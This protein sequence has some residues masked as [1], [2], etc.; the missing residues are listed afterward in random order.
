MLETQSESLAA[1]GAHDAPDAIIV[2][3]GPNGLSAA[4]ALAEAGADVLVLE[5][6]SSIGG[7]T[8]TDTLTLP[9]FHHDVC[10]AAHPMGILSPYW[11]TLPLEDHGLEWVLPDASVAHPLDDEPAVML[12]RDIARTADNLGADAARWRRM[13]APLVERHEDLLG[14]ALG[15]LGIPSHPI[16]LMRFGLKAL[17]PATWLAKWRFREDRARALFAGCAAHSILPLNAWFTSALGVIFAVT[18]HAVEWPVAKGGSHAITYALASYLESQGGRILTDHPVR[19][20][21]DLP[22]ARVVLFDTDPVQMAE[23]VGDAL[24][25]G[26]RSRLRTY[27]FGP[28]AFKVDWA[29]DEPIPWRDP[30]CNKASTVHVGGT[31]DEVAAAE[32]AIW[33]GKHPDE[34]FVLVVQQ[35]EFDATRAPGGKH[36]GYAYCHVPHG[37]SKDMTAAIE[38]QIERFAPGFKDTILARHT[39]SVADFEAYNPNYV[40]GAITGGAA[41]WRQLFTRPVARI[42]PYTT[43]NPRVLICSASTPPGGGVHGMCGYH[44]AQT[45][46]KRLERFEAAPFYST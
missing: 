12:W 1:L 24:P 15:P 23:I 38:A 46:L 10:A 37:S 40:G 14:D 44:A 32:A 36:T 18:G 42:N 7:G 35:S 11:R 3:A 34:P 2:G 13:M 45:A 5:A 22:A 6:A 4:V 26:Y 19:S 17:W 41:D 33:K 8:R 28:G 30:Q 20:A 43:P 27:R 21:D 29:L 39:M 16:T 25:A 31:I 9:D